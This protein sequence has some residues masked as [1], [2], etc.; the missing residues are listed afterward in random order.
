MKGEGAAGSAV[1]VAEVTRT[2]VTMVGVA[3]DAAG[4]IVVAA[5][6]EKRLSGTA[7]LCPRRA[8]LRTF[9]KPM[10][11]MASTIVPRSRLGDGISW[12][13]AMMPPLNWALIQ[14]GTIPGSKPRASALCPWSK[15]ATEAVAAPV[16]FPGAV[17]EGKGAAEAT[18]SRSDAGAGLS[19]SGGALKEAK[20]EEVGGG[21]SG[22][23][24]ALANGDSGVGVNSEEIAAGWEGMEK[25]EPGSGIMPKGEGGGLVGVGA[26]AEISK[27]GMGGSE[28]AGACEGSRRGGRIVEAGGAGADSGIRNADGGDGGSGCRRL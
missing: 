12:S 19:G 6:G 13:S 8:E 23:M 1:G 22:A 10:S 27:K 2:D 4:F 7:T 11:M 5:T 3:A 18:D 24:G 17:E 25:G 9:R 20:G 28:L 15:A 26:E 21:G 14:E 16:N